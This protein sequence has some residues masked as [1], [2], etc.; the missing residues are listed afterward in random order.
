MVK[1]ILGLSLVMTMMLVGLIGCGSSEPTELAKDPVES[2]VKQVEVKPEEVK[3][4]AT[5]ATAEPAKPVES[6]TPIT[7]AGGLGDAVEVFEQKY[8]PGK[9]SSVLTSYRGNY[10]LSMFIDEKGIKRA[11][12][13]SL[14]FEST[15]QPRRTKEEVIQIV[16][17][18]IPAD[19]KTTK[20]WTEDGKIKILYE[21]ET[22]AKTFENY[23]V[24]AAEFAKKMGLEADK[25][26]TFILIMNGDDKGIFGAVLGLGDN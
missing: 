6:V 21:S 9:E 20:E 22:L 26:G 8:G 25:P 23:H 19:A 3:Q 7:A 1:K 4:E 14:Q 24:E 13:V 17:D 16:K 12:N 2:E 11:Y 10:I 18:M 15:D 5:P